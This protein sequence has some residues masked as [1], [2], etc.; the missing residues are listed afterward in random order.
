MANVCAL[1]A[2]DERDE[3]ASFLLVCVMFFCYI[4]REIENIV[5]A[6]L[7]TV[8]QH[9]RKLLIGCHHSHKL[10][11]IDATITVGVGAGN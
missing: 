4:K 6:I 10:V 9:K 1:V 5:P 3:R 2:S 7:S 11:E 8:Q